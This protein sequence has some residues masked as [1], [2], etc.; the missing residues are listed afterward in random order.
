[1]NT[2]FI[3]IVDPELADNLVA[4]G[5]QYIKEGNTFAFFYSEELISVIQQKFQKTQFVCERKLR[6]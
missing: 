6:F 2:Q 5:F 4:L 1:M 3:K